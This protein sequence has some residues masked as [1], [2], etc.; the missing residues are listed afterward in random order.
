MIYERK[1]NNIPSV[2]REDLAIGDKIIRYAQECVAEQNDN[3]PKKTSVILPRRKKSTAVRILK[4]AVA[5]T[6]CFAIIF[7]AVRLDFFDSALLAIADIAEK[8]KTE[9]Y[10][11]NNSLPEVRTLYTMQYTQSSEKATADVVQDA[12]GEKGIAQMEEVAAAGSTH[13]EGYVD[14]TRLFPIKALDL[15]AKDIYSLNNET[16]FDPDVRYLS[17]TIPSS[18]ENIDTQNG[19]L[20]LIVHTHGTECYSKS[21]DMY[22]EGEESR[23]DDTSENVVRVGEEIAAT[24]NNFGIETIHC[25]TMHD[26]ASFINAY[27]SSAK[28][29]RGYLEEYPSI[30]FVIDVHRDAIIRDDGESVKAVSEIAGED[31]AQLMFVVGTNQ[32]GHNHPEWQENLSLALL[33]QKEMSQT[34][35]SLCR[36]INLR[37]VPFNQQLSD[38]Y[39][40]LEAGTSANTLDEALRSARAFGENLARVILKA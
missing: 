36:S 14:G 3:L 7:S 29:V 18:L 19:P 34:Y 12:V 35:P 21:T 30:R 9:D 24:L 11:E 32:L 13:V 40:L 16:T 2:K 17:Q 31:Y 26:K 10:L 27:T 5:A 37:D 23:S 8:G 22:P 4:F 20:V 25:S 1:T 6:V 39:L 38:G 33:L 28:A 15:S